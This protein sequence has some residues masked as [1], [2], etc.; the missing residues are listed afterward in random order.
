MFWSAK[1]FTIDEDQFL[2]FFFFI[3]FAFGV[4]C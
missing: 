2:I 3:A 4:L 1:D